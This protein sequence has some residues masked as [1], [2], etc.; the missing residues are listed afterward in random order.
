MVGVQGQQLRVVA[1]GTLGEEFGV[2]VVGTRGTVFAVR[3]GFWL[4][5]DVVERHL[6][7]VG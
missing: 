2:V 6:A 5:V 3:E 4:N 7:F 1:T